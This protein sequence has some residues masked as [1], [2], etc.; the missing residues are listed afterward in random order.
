MYLRTLV[1]LFR[2]FRVCF[3]L[4]VR[5]ADFLHRF[6]VLSLSYREFYKLIGDSLATL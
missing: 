1:A 6:I 4:C 3:V 2:L 5:P